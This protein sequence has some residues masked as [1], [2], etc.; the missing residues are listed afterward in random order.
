MGLFWTLPSTTPGV[1]AGGGFLPLYSPSSVGRICHPWLNPVSVSGLPPVAVHA[2]WLVIGLWW[3]L[4]CGVADGDDRERDHF[5]GDIQK[6][7]RAP[8]PLFVR[9]HSQPDGAEALRV[10]GQQQVFN[11]GTSILEPEA[12]VL[13]L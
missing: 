13:F 1:V 11:S 10:G 8:D 4:F 12:F 2:I 9:V 5:V 7:P 3:F 6:F